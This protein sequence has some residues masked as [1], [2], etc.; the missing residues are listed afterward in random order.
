MQNK[1]LLD[2][3][4]L[5]GPLL[6]FGGPYSN[7][8]ALLAIK[9]KAE[10]YGIPPEQC[11]CTGDIVA[12][13]AQPQETVAAIRE[14]GIHCLMGNCEASFASNADDCG[15]GF[16][17]GTHCDLLS[18]QWFQFA[19]QALSKDDRQWFSTLPEHMRFSINGQSALVVHGSV[20]SMNQFVFASSE[21]AILKQECRKADADMIIGGH[22]GIPFTRTIDHDD[23]AQT[24]AKSTIW[25]NAG[26]IGMPANDGTTRTWFSLIN[27]PDEKCNDA[28]N[29]AL[30]IEIHAL[31]YNHLSLIHI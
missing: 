7:L 14:W 11:I 24:S 4:E 20:S 18:A 8:P 6:I 28:A 26:A 16:E 19:N 27:A 31:T 30:S 9:E 25:H 1:A 5:T 12:Y 29:R 22:C 15:C 21:D 10:Q 23:S 3:G 17:E 13:C 2:L